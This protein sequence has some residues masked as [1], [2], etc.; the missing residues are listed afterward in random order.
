MKG[1]T[2]HASP[3]E[4]CGQ[5]NNS[6]NTEGQNQHVRIN[7]FKARIG[8]TKRDLARNHSQEAADPHTVDPF[9]IRWSGL[10]CCEPAEADYTRST[11]VHSCFGLCATVACL[12]IFGD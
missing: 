2:K 3:N 4:I 10:P 8:A 7:N 12:N 9:C 1:T 5:T 6:T 11:I